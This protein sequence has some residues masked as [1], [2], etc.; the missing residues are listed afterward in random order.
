[1]VPE[2]AISGYDGHRG[3]VWLVREGRLSQAELTFGARDDKGRAEVIDGVPQGASIVALPPKGVAQGRL[4][5]IGN[6]P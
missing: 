2:S 5:W 1:M 3:R 4:A 6:P